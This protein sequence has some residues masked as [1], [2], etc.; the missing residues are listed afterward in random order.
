MVTPPEPPLTF[1]AH[2]PLRQALAERHL[3][4]V[5]RAYRH[6]PYHGT[7]PLPQRTVAGWL[8]VTQAQLSRMENG[9][10]VVHL[11]RLIHAA[12]VLRIPAH[13]LWFQLPAQPRSPSETL[14]A[15]AGEAGLHLVRALRSADRQIGGRNLYGAVLAHLAGFSVTAH[16]SP[17]AP[18]SLLAA[19]VS[20][21]EMAGWMAHDS[22]AP[23]TARIHL[24]NALG[25]AAEGGDQRLIGQIRGSLSHLACHE[26]D[27]ETAIAHASAGLSVVAGD[28]ADALIRARLLALQAHGF[29]V[30]G[31]GQECHIALAAAEAALSEDGPTSS[32][33]LSP[34]DRTSFSIEAARCL[35]R[36]NDLTAVLRVLDDVPVGRVTT[37]VRSQALAR[38]C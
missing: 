24:H 35:L 18:R 28:N 19:V 5:V 12:R 7:Q 29:A 4:R 16:R 17:S 34:F 26:G 9:S 3:G 25:L 37:R 22:G 36:L 27:A 38:C 15:D 23:T 33:W 32:E 21:H 14:P 8:G 31:R 13:E 1:W 2:E 30:A 20:L 11:D 6:H 10:P